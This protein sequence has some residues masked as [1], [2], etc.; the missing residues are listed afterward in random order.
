A[1][2]VGR[3]NDAG[4]LACAGKVG[5]GF[6][7]ESSQA[8]RR[9]LESLATPTCPFTPFPAGFRRR[10]VH[11]VRP[12]LTADVAFSEWTHD[13]KIR[14]ASFRGVVERRTPAPQEPRS[15]EGPRA[16]VRLTHPDRV[17]YPDLGLTKRD[18]AAY[19]ETVAKWIVP[20]VAGRPLTLVRCPNGVDESCFF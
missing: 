2:I 14:Q 9:R 10:G 13:G 18:V 5:T 20:H 11:W 4:R 1:L 19:Y 8:V 6:T 15:D 17:L 12:E 16:L 7:H 3:R